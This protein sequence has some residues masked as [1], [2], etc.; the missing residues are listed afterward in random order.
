MTGTDGVHAL[1][2]TLLDTVRELE[3]HIGDRADVLA[4]E[5][6]DAAR[7]GFERDLAAQEEKARWEQQRLEDL[8]AELRRQLD[9]QLAQVD[10]TRN[11]L[12]EN[13]I[14]PRT[15]LANTRRG[16]SN[17]LITGLARALWSGDREFRRLTDAGW[18]L[19]SE[20]ERVRW[21][22]AAAH[23]IESTVDHILEA[24]RPV[25]WTTD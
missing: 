12:T 4:A 15:G 10:R 9:A 8:N 20:D 2:E 13:G 1:A 3:R 17:A 5:R 24:G 14:D 25:W 18:D 22:R 6:V 19:L 11:L 21:E 7:A 16:A 23:A